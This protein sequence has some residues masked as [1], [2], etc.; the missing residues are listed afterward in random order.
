MLRT[1][2]VKPSP[3]KLSAISRNGRNLHDCA[4]RL[5]N[6]R[7]VSAGMPAGLD[8]GG[9]ASNHRFSSLA[10]PEMDLTPTW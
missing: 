4:K 1:S 7:E 10:Y 6:E 3:Y 9:N 8:L 5:E 2:S